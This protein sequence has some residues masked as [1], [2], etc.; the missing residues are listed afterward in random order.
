MCTSTP[1]RTGPAG[2]AEPG[3]MASSLPR[4]RFLRI[5]P[6]PHLYAVLACASLLL[7]LASASLPA[8]QQTA[9][10]GPSRSSLPETPLPK[11]PAEEGLASVAGTVLDLSGGTISGADVNLMLRALRPLLLWSSSSR[12]SRSMSFPTSHCQLR[13][14]A[15]R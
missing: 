6:R 11:T 1:L 3:N 7:F 14:R 12:T 4:K 8:Q 13:Q 10:L 2:L 9:E 5:A 15:S